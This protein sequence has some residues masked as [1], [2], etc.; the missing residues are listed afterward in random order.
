MGE[1]NSGARSASGRVPGEPLGRLEDVPA[2]A[3]AAAEQRFGSIVQASVARADG[4]YRGE[5]VSSVTHLAQ[6]VSAARVVFHPKSHLEFVSDRHRWADDNARLNGSELQ[7]HY[8][9]DKGKVYPLDRLRE[10]VG[11]VV[12]SMK[13]IAT[14]RGLPDAAQFGRTLDEV[15]RAFVE[16]ERQRA[17]IRRTSGLARSE[18]TDRGSVIGDRER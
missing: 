4:S 10:N 5:V 14:E 1:E 6:C 12:A 18:R 9:G 16:Q 11:W 15:G 17:T 2:E 7:I 3:R 8:L 13:R